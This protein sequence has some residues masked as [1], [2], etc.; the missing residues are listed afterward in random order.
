M[1]RSRISARVPPGPPQT[2]PD[3]CHPVPR[4]DEMQLIEIGL[5]HATADLTVRERLAVSNA[6]LPGV[7][8]DLREIAADAVVL[9][10]CNRVEL[11]LL[12]AEAEIGVQ[13]AIGYLADRSGL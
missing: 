8:A 11:Y 7:L 5:D 12:V 9:S 2:V 13:R 1:C 4:G 10:T 6:D 3:Y